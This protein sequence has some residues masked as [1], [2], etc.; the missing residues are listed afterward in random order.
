MIL[1]A[2]IYVD[3][4]GQNH[5]I[6]LEPGNY[7]DR[8]EIVFAPGEA[9]GINDFDVSKLAINQ[10]NDIQQLSVFNPNGLDVKSIEVYDIAGKRMLNRQYNGVSNRYDLST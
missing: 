1:K 4:K 3:L 10:N 2:D 6:N 7:T 5:H 9:L 8:F